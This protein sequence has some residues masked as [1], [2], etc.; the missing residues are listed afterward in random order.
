[1]INAV[2]GAFLGRMAPGTRQYTAVSAMEGLFDMVVLVPNLAVTWRRF[3]DIGKSGAWSLMGLIATVVSTAF[4]VVLALTYSAT[5]SAA[6]DAVMA[7]VGLTVIGMFLA[8]IVVLILM[9]VW[10]C[11]EGQAGPNRY[12]PDPKRPETAAGEKAPWEY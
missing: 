10:L 3:H 2:F 8:V 9:L 11:R 1:V 12:G 5:G 6:S 7:S 4:V